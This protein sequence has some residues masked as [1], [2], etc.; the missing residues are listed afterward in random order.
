MRGGGGVQQREGNSARHH[1]S[2]KHQWPQQQ[3]LSL[4]TGSIMM[5]EP[6]IWQ[7]GG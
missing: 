6:D 2:S 1:C 3:H 7:G 5:G 4:M